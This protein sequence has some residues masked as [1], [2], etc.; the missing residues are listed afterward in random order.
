MNLIL[1]FGALIFCW[2]LANHYQ[3]KYNSLQ[4]RIKYY[5]Y[6]LDFEKKEREKYINGLLHLTYESHP[7]QIVWL[8]DVSDD[9]IRKWIRDLQN[10]PSP[11]PL[12]I[13][14]LQMELQRRKNVINI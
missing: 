5:D 1:I 12:A 4:R 14:F 11:K 13:A 10:S 6:K 8:E 9:I 7:E 2:A 3:K